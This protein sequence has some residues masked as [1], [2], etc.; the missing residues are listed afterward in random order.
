MENNPFDGYMELEAIHGR[1]VSSVDG[2]Q[3]VS[4]PTLD[5]LNAVQNAAELA[6]WAMEDQSSK[7]RPY[8]TQL[9]RQAK[10]DIPVWNIRARRQF[11][12]TMIQ[13][14]SDKEAELEKA[15]KEKVS[16]NQ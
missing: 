6:V 11:D 13:W 1:I 4:R 5:L 3:V 2:L 10:E 16:A 8:L 7:K 12:K 9:C 14:L 15:A